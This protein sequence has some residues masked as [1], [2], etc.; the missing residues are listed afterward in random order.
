MLPLRTV[1]RTTQP[2]IPK[3]HQCRD[4]RSE[5][6]VGAPGPVP[7]AGCHLQR[8]QKVGQGS[9]P[10]PAN[11]VPGSFVW[12]KTD[13]TGVCPP[14]D[15]GRWTLPGSGARDMYSDTLKAS[16]CQFCSFCKAC[17]APRQASC[18]TSFSSLAAYP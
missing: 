1:L 14:V 5:A 3:C 18:K 15:T 9:Q 6:R 11:L 8:A 2:S 4:K 17:L 7:V 10:V 12:A 16:S 13:H